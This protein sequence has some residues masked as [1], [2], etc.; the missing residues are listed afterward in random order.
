MTDNKQ[1]IRKY[2]NV[3]NEGFMDELPDSSDIVDPSMDDPMDDIATTGPETKI[4]VTMKDGDDVEVEVYAKQGDELSRLMKMAGMFH[5]DKQNGTLNDSPD[6]ADAVSIPDVI[7][8]TPELEIP[9]DDAYIASEPT[10]MP[11]LDMGSDA[12]IDMPVLDMDGMDDV[13]EDKNG[14]FGY[15]NPLAGQEPYE[16]KAY[17]HSGGA[18]KRTHYV[19]AQSGDNPMDAPISE[20]KGLKSM[21]QEVVESRKK[22]VEEGINDDSADDVVSKLSTGVAVD[23]NTLDKLKKVAGDVGQGTSPDETDSEKMDDVLDAAETQGVKLNPNTKKE[24]EQNVNDQQKDDSIS[25]HEFKINIIDEDDL[26]ER[27]NHYSF[28]P[29]NQFGRGIIRTP[30]AKLKKSAKRGLSKFKK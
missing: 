10:D 26:E 11:I 1:D 6:T 19:P 28:Y 7:D 29:D 14:D 3:I 4:E 15:P 13:S 18:T 8:V 2:L 21:M 20:K 16:L 23:S 12:E 25:E 30:A 5:A 24:L 17:D 9:A 27:K 22:K